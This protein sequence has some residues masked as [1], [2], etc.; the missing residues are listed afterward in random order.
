MEFTKSYGIKLGNYVASLPLSFLW[1]VK[2]KSLTRVRLCDPMDCSLPGSSVQGIYQ[3]RVL[4]WVAISFSRGSSQSRDQ[5]RVSCTAGRRFTI[6]V[7]K[8]AKR[9]KQLCPHHLSEAMSLF[10]KY[11]VYFICLYFFIQ[12]SY[13]YSS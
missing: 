7:T 8:E 2:V 12:C 13:L 9:I 5:T 11:P 6:W 3:A 1:K 4:E 10:L